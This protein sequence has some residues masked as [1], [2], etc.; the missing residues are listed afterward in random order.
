MLSVPG[1]TTTVAGG[2]VCPVSGGGVDLLFPGDVELVQA[3]EAATEATSAAQINRFI[4]SSERRRCR[5]SF[6][7]QRVVDTV[8]RPE[9]RRGQTDIL[10]W[11]GGRHAIHGIV[12]AV[13]H[14]VV[15]DID[16]DHEQER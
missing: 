14:A 6:R 1:L 4:A 2:P 3:L 8:P 7:L 9:F 10:E 13:A 15:A 12:H 11:L 16:S 5:A